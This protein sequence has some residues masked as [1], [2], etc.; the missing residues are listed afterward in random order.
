[1]YLRKRWALSE[2]H[3]VTTQSP[4]SKPQTQYEYG[5]DLVLQFPFLY[6]LQ[7]EVGGPFVRTPTSLLRDELSGRSQKFA[8]YLWMN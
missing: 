5:V 1:M 8:R 7:F 2:L 6:K 3:G 4:P